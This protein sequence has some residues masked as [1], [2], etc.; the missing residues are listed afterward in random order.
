MPNIDGHSGVGLFIK[1]TPY[2]HPQIAAQLLVHVETVHTAETEAQLRRGSLW[3][4]PLGSAR[5]G[6]HLKF[7]LVG[8]PTED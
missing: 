5:Q 2:P 4:L 7:R 1:H 3:A 6:L 8:L